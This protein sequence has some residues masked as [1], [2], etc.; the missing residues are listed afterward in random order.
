MSNPNTVPTLSPVTSATNQA[1]ALTRH[2]VNTSVTIITVLG[3]FSLLPA[4]K[5]QKAVEVLQKIGVDAHNL[6]GDISDLWFIIGPSIIGIMWKLSTSSASL[7]NELK[8]LTRNPAVVIPPGSTI[9]VPPAVAA[10]VPSPKVVPN[11]ANFVG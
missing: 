2:V 6:F 11:G 3:G 8:S 7:I 1:W 9:E 10:A 4:D 5:V